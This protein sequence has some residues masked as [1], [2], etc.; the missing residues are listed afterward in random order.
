MYYPFFYGKQFELLAIREFSTLVSPKRIFPIIEP[1]KNNFKSLESACEALQQKAFH[2]IVIVNPSC[3]ELVDSS[4]QIDAFL[5]KT[6][7]FNGCCHK[8]FLVTQDTT[9]EQIQSITKD[10][11]EGYYLIHDALSNDFSDICDFIR[12]NKKKIAGHVFYRSNISDIKIKTIKKIDKGK[13]FISLQDGFIKRKNADYPFKEF[14]SDQHILYT[15]QFTGFSDYLMVGR[16][17]SET[18]GPAY[19]IAIHLTFL[20]KNDDDIMKIF[21]FKSDSSATYRNPA[22]KFSEA[23]TKMIS[24]IDNSPEDLILNSSAIQDYRRL[25]NEGHYPGLGALKK[26]SM[27]H[28][29]QTLD[30]YLE[31]Q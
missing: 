30:N 19:A 2:F 5:N 22:G 16:E 10:W 8:G 11:G 14:F 25:N 15:D 31:K 4:E 20:D 13:E 24:T 27:I 3:G 6:K 18:G 21:H 28:H 17:Y 23:L 9:V 29:I 7:C 26:L 12:N 1:V